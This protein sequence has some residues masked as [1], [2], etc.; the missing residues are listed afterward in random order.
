M[1]HGYLETSC[2]VSDVVLDEGVKVAAIVVHKSFH[3]GDE[4]RSEGFESGVAHKC[5]GV[6]GLSALEKGFRLRILREEPQQQTSLVG[7]SASIFTRS[8]MSPFTIR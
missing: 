2:V 8:L 3:S 5:P 1:F 6:D 7:T 4:L